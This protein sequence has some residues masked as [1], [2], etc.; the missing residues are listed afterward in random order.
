LLKFPAAPFVRHR[1]NSS[2]FWVFDNLVGICDEQTERERERERER[3]D[4]ETN[5]WESQFRK[6][7]FPKIPFYTCSF[8]AWEKGWIDIADFDRHIGIIFTCWRLDAYWKSSEQESW[9]MAHARQLLILYHPRSCSSR[10][11]VLIDSTGLENPYR[12][13]GPSAACTSV[14][15]KLKQ[16]PN[17]ISRVVPCIFYMKEISNQISHLLVLYLSVKSERS[18]WNNPPKSAELTAP[19]DKRIPFESYISPALISIWLDLFR[20]NAEA[21]ITLASSEVGNEK[22]SPLSPP[23]PYFFLSVSL[24]LL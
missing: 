16:D 9:M 8:C 19:V 20:R 5:K 6:Q 4:W 15:A 13:R 17:R 18:C 7:E 14:Q 3:D 11:N 12:S 23:P 21:L 2:S 22:Y 24:C 1:V 10:S